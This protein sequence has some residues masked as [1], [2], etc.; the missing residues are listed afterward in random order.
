MYQRLSA[1]I[2]CANVLSI[3]TF[4]VSLLFGYKEENIICNP[5]MKGNKW[6]FVT[7][8]QIRRSTS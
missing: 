3:G 6:S 7:H 8:L 4:N 5:L 2:G 1:R